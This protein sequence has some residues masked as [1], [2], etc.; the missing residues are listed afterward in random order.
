MK[1]NRLLVTSQYVNSSEWDV[2][3]TEKV[4][5]KVVYGCCPVPFVDIT[6]KITLLRK[7][8]YYVWNVITPCLLLIATILFG[9]FL[10]PESGERVSLSI[11]LLLAFVVFLQLISTSLPRNYDS[12]PIL[13][14]FYIAIMTESALSFVATCIVLCAHS[15]SEKGVVTMPNWIR[16][17]FL[18]IIA[19]FLCIRSSKSLPNPTSICVCNTHN[20]RREKTDRKESYVNFGEFLNISQ[21]KHN[22]ILSNLSENKTS[23]VGTDN[24]LNELEIIKSSINWR[25]NGD[26]LQEEWK[27]L[28]RVLDRLFFWLFLLT[29]IVC[30]TCILVPAYFIYN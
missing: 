5:H 27:L 26:R 3:Q 25:H 20:N 17:F 18:H 9:F 19:K 30:S 21:D 2:V 6:F 29:A 1:D 28:G 4:I 22:G 15:R 16:R 23:S 11:T 24:I 14:I 13:T 7:P 12:V 8:L 10:P